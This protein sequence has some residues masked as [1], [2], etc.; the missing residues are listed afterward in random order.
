MTEYIP[1][2]KGWRVFNG[3]LIPDAT[4]WGYLHRKQIV[5]G[6]CYTR[7]CRRNYHL[8]FEL[9]LRSGYAYVRM[10][11][12]QRLLRCNMP[13]GCRMTFQDDKGGSGLPL[14]ILAANP[15]VRIVFRCGGCKWEKAITPGQAIAQLVAAK[16]GT[17]STLHTELVTKT[18]KP[19]LKCGASKWDCDVRWPTPPNDKTYGERRLEDLARER[20]VIPR[21]NDG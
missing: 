20:V 11:E 15:E 12:I 9:L 14:S 18:S 8:D 19:C 3:Q 13:G 16:T 5:R 21:A 2:P 6:S 10:P 7:D 4:L 17:S 1:P